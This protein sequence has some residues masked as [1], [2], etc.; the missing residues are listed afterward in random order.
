MF[1]M[2]A[3]NDVV[4][5][6]GD[7]TD[8]RKDSGIE[9]PAHGVTTLKSNHTDV[10]LLKMEGYRPTEIRGYGFHTRITS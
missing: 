6:M 8:V 5:L 10:M 9:Y 4:G 7:H 1:G 2:I 3:H